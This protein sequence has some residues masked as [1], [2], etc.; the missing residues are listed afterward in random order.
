[1]FL[2]ED[3]TKKFL[4]DKSVDETERLVYGFRE[5]G[6]IAKKTAQVIS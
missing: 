4:K 1:M 2:T 5:N 6:K 3:E